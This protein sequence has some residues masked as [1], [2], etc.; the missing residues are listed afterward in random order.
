[1][2]IFKIVFKKS[3]GLNM[4]KDLHEFHGENY[5]MLL[6]IWKKLNKTERL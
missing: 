2:T 3:L 5:K 4:V 1:M 6:K